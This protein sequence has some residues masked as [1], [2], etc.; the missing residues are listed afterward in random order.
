MTGIQGNT[1][2]KGSRNFRKS[3]I[4]NKKN[5]SYIQQERKEGLRKAGKK[6]FKKLPFP[7]ICK[8]GKK[9]IKKKT[10]KKKAKISIKNIQFGIRKTER[11]EEKPEEKSFGFF[12]RN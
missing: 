12:H 3:E 9:A 4:N 8:G 11:K 7:Q 2:R 10:A 6:G 5:N 1:Y